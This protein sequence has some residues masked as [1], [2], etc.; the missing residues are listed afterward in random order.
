MYCLLPKLPDR[1]QFILFVRLHQAVSYPSAGWLC[2]SQAN[3]E[4][5][6]VADRPQA[7]HEPIGPF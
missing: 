4:S 3:P 5:S 7:E 2:V 1:N 6:N